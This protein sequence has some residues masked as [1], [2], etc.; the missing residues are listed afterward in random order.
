MMSFFH[1]CKEGGINCGDSKYLIDFLKFL[2]LGPLRFR[3]QFPGCWNGCFRHFGIFFFQFSKTLGR[4]TN[5]VFLYSSYS[6]LAVNIFIL[7][8]SIKPS[9]KDSRQTKAK[10]T[11]ILNCD[12]V[13]NSYLWFSMNTSH[14]SK[15]LSFGNLWFKFHSIWSGFNLKMGKPVSINFL[16]FLF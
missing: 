12:E 10:K 7:N 9:G 16:N 6:I 1:L 13:I 11:N 14:H 5:R 8:S 2:Q 15:L 3:S 4:R